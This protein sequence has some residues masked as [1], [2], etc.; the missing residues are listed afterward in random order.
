MLMAWAEDDE[1]IPFNYSAIFKAVIA[2]IQLETYPSGGH[3][4]TVANIEDFAPKMIRFLAGEK[5]ESDNPDPDA[6]DPDDTDDED[7]DDDDEDEKDD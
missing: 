7:L 6:I 2:N 1:V 3:N 4:A 5:P